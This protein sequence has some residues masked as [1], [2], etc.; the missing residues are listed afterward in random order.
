MS[1]SRQVRAEEP[2]SQEWLKVESMDLEA[3]GVAHNAAGKV[4]FIDGALSG[5]VADGTITFIRNDQVGQ[6]RYWILG[7][8]LMLLMIYR[9]QGILGDKKE[10]ALDAR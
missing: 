1:R 5:A 8:A 9:P 6:V 10:L 2:P 7:L 4:V 3:Q